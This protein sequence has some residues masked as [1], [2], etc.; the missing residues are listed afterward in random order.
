MDVRKTFALGNTAMR[1]LASLRGAVVVTHEIRGCRFAQPPGSTVHPVGM[2]GGRMGRGTTKDTKATKA[3]GLGFRVFRVFR[4]SQ[5][6]RRRGAGAA[7]LV[8]VDGAL[9]WGPVASVRS[10]VGTRLVS[11]WDGRGR[12]RSRRWGGR[13]RGATHQGELG[14]VDGVIAPV[15]SRWGGANRGGHQRG[16]GIVAG[17]IRSQPGLDAAMP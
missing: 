16:R 15:L 5:S 12:P 3:P 6:P 2:G 10:V 4:G 8:W 9:G 17:F 1:V 7:N 11:R 14:L 13:A